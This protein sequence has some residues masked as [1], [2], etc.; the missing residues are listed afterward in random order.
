MSRASFRSMREES[1]A[2]ASD[3]VGGGAGS[4]HGGDGGAEEQLSGDTGVI[5]GGEGA[6]RG[7]KRPAVH[8]RYSSRMP[9]ARTTSPQDV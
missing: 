7:K 6:R 3:R 4:G 9:V 2:A 8:P 5:A 1:A